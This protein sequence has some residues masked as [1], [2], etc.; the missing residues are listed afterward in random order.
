[1]AAEQDAVLPPAAVLAVSAEVPAA[2]SA[3]A[4]S[5]AAARSRAVVAASVAVEPGEN[6]LQLS[7]MVS[8]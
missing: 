8:I 2:V 7:N 6:N 3:E 5:K 1:M 4:R